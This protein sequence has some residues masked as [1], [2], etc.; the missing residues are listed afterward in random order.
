[1]NNDTTMRKIVLA[2]N[3]PR[4]RELLG[5]LGY[6]YEVRVLDGID[7]SY[8][9]T[10]RGSEVAAYI[11]RAKADAYRA[12]MADDEIIITA[13]TIVC[14]D[15]MVLGKPADEAE[16]VAMLRSLSGRTHQVYT[17]VTIVAAEQSSTFVSRS[18]VVFAMLT[19]EEIAHYVAHYRP[20]D[21]AGAYGIQEWIGYI[22][23]ERIEGSYFNVMGL[24]VQRLYTELKKYL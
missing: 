14:L 5:G 9:D 13:D 6:D 19:D 8:P 10:L 7:E 16:A 23:V 24:P 20:M 4:R 3:S 18:D 17:G 12:T 22:G 15:D 11:S 2:S 1:M 21:K